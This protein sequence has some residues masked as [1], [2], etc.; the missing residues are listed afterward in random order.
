[1]EKGGEIGTAIGALILIIIREYL[2]VLRIPESGRKIVEAFLV[3][4]LL[5]NAYFERGKK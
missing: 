1:M 2:T 3:I 4:L 5:I